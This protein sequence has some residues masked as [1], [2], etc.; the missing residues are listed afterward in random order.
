VSFPRDLKTAFFK[1]FIEQ[2]KPIA[3]PIQNLELIFDA[4]A[5]HINSPARRVLTKLTIHKE[6]QAVD[7]FPHICW[8]RAQQ[9]F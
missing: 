7:G 8:G 5:K 2:A 4:I 9:D 1:A 6:T 3:I